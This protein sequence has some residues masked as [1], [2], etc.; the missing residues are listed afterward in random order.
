MKK[1]C[2][3]CSASTRAG[4]RCKN[5]TCIYGE[6]CNVHTKALFDLAIK[7]S[8][9]PKSGKGLFTLKAIAKNQKIVKYTG[10]IKTLDEYNKNPSGYAVAISKGR[11]IDAASTQSELGRYAN[12]CRASNRK[13]G[14]CN[15]SNARFSVSYKGGTPTIWIKSTKNIPANSEIY[16]SYGHEYWN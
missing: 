13:A 5:N 15:G 8:K 14:Q 16:I 7:P 2:V 4:A 9:I 6:F 10:E 11:V 12:D 3:Q 1:D